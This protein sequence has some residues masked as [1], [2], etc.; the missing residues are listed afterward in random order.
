MTRPVRLHTL[1][2]SLLL[3][4]FL[5]WLSLR[6]VDFTEFIESVRSAHYWWILPVIGVTL[7]SHWI[8]AYR[9]QALIVALPEDSKSRVSTLDLFASVMVGYMVNY[10]VPRAGEIARCAHLSTRKKFSFSA[11]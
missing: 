11:L 3:A 1:L 6:D 4:A 10:A 2:L 7:L 9:W 8:R 5:I